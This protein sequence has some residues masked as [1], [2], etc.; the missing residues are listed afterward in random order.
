MRREKYVKSFKTDRQDGKL[1]EAGEKKKRGGTKQVRK[2]LFI[3]R[4]G[5]E[6]R[7]E[8]PEGSFKRG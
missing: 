6:A 8:H 3:L 4:P 2:G 5:T 7:S 1:F